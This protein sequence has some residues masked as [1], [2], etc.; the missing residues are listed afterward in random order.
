[1]GFYIEVPHPLN[2]VQQILDRFEGA[3][4][5]ERPARFRDI[6]EGKVL[7]CVVSNGPFDAALICYDEEQFLRPLR[8]YQLGDR[9]PTEYLL[10]DWKDAVTNLGMDPRQ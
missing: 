1:M 4:V 5:V 9:R 6:P 2:K 3:R 8:A 10:I 7:I